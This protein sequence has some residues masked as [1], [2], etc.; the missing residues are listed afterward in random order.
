MTLCIIYVGSPK[1]TNSKDGSTAE[2]LAAENGHADIVAL[3]KTP[4]KAER[5][6]T[7]FLC[8]GEGG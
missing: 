4:C 2:S 3:L 5:S 7:G 8:S 6:S 1:G